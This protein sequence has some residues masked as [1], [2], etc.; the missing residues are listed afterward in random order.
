M[1]LYLFFHF[2]ISASLVTLCAS[3]QNHSSQVNVDVAASSYR[4][5]E[6]TSVNLECSIGYISARGILQSFKI[7]LLTRTEGRIRHADFANF[8]WI[9][10]TQQTDLAACGEADGGIPCPLWHQ[11]Q[12]EARQMVINVML[13]LTAHR[14]F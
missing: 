1:A 8:L 7:L 6:V 2:F 10:G 3:V 14:A 11:V 5:T 12:Q 4:T 9:M 13:D